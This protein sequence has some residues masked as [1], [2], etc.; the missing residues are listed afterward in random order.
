[1][2]KYQNSDFVLMQ[3]TLHQRYFKDKHEKT[4]NSLITSPLCPIDFKMHDFYDMIIISYKDLI[5]LNNN[6]KEILK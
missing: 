1:M 5:L 2:N 3:N 6:I 4:K